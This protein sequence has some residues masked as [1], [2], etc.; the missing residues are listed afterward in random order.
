MFRLNHI[1]IVV[2]I[3]L[4]TTKAKCKFPGVMDPDTAV[5]CEE[6]PEASIAR[7]YADDNHKWMKDFST[8]IQAMIDNGNEDVLYNVA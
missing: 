4:Q 6:R 8:A 1:V 5:I 2:C 3:F 7:D